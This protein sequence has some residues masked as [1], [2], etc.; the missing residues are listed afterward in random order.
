[1]KRLAL[2]AAGAALAGLTACTGSTPSATPAGS[3]PSATPGSATSSATPAGSAAVTNSPSA[4]TANCRQQYHAWTQGPGKGLVAALDA[5]GAAEAAGDM[6][7][8]KV[9]LNETKPALARASRHPLPGCAD[10]M[11]YWTVL[12]M[13]VSAAAASTGSAAT[14]TAAMKGV[15]TLVRKLDAE[16]KRAGG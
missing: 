16:L 2:A 3:T 4:I 12:M 7:T 5:V 15:P 9:V 8:L 11:G 13:H 10:P 1:M 14:L 6:H